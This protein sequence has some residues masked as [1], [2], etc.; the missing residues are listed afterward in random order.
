M[1]KIHFLAFLFFSSLSFAQVTFKL[2][3]RAGANF[4]HF[5]QGKGTVQNG[6]IEFNEGTDSYSPVEIPYKF[7]NRTDFYIGFF[8][9]IRLAK[10]YA[11]QPEFNYSRQGSKVETPIKH[12]RNEYKISYFGTQLINKFYFKN[13]NVLVG[14]TVDIVVEKDFNPSYDFDIGITAGGGYDITQNLGVEARVKHGFLHTINNY[15]GKHANV[16]F[17]AGLYYTFNMKK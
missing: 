12:T 17:Q 4:T 16:V 14:P 13:F 7:T 1:K 5:T 15:Q 8:G 2:G 6:E 10:F 3:L 11:L 9:N